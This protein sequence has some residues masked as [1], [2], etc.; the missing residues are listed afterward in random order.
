MTVADAAAVVDTKRRREMFAHFMAFPP[1][2]IAARAL[3]FVI[4]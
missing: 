4:R 2:A 1:R 3:F